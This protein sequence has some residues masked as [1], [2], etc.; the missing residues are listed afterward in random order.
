MAH[1]E[2][3]WIGIL[4]LTDVKSSPRPLPRVTCGG[5]RVRCVIV[6]PS[7]RTL[8]DLWSM[9]TMRGIMKMSSE[10]WCYIL[11]VI[12]HFLLL[13]E[14]TRLEPREGNT[15]IP[16]HQLTTSWRMLVS[17]AGRC[18][19][20]LHVYYCE[21]SLSEEDLVSK[22]FPLASRYLSPNWTFLPSYCEFHNILPWAHWQCFF[23]F[24]CIW[25][26]H[27]ITKTITTDQ[28]Q[29]TTFFQLAGRP[30][31][32]GSISTCSS[33]TWELRSSTQNPNPRGT[34]PG[35]SSEGVI[36]RISLLWLW[37]FGWCLASRWSDYHPADWPNNIAKAGTTWVLAVHA[38]PRAKWGPQFRKPCV[39]EKSREMNTLFNIMPSDSHFTWS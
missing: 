6:V 17:D 25:W 12:Q 30:S 38:S 8:D 5:F 18:N 14:K 16:N 34:S 11:L 37:L 10:Y 26:Y 7:R 9:P 28:S 32:C 33:D 2:S 3:Q 39:M 27:G 4:P 31:D 13:G 35:T 15:E 21:R 19:G 20:V 29:P 22:I 1:S 36:R 24:K 23:A